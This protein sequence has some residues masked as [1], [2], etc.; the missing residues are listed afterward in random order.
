MAPPLAG[1]ILV[2]DDEP[3]IAR[4]LAQLL[5]RD[6]H[7]VETADNGSRALALLHER[8]YDVIVCDLH[9]PDLD[10]PAFYAL[11]TQQYPA[12]RQRVI[13]LTG[14]TGG[15]GSRTFLEQSGRPWLRKPSP[16]ATIRRAIQDV[17]QACPPAQH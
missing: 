9:M 13:F 3:S 2:I 5:R 1:T 8:R 17:L 10:G 12:L 4:G 6:G 14:N 11:L 7:S 16:I 15:A